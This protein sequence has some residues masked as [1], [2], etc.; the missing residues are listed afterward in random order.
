MKKNLLLI[1]DDQEFIGLYSQILEK[2]FDVK[3][4]HSLKEALAILEDDPFAPDIVLTDI[5]MPETNGFEIYDFFMRNK[6][7]EHFH[8]VFKTSSLNKSVMEESIVN[9][10][11]ELISTYMGNDEIIARLKKSLATS[12]VFKIMKRSE[13]KLMINSQTGKLIFPVQDIPIDFTDTEIKILKCLRD[14][15]KHTPKNIILEYCFGKGIVVTDNNFNT[16][17]TNLRKKLGEVGASIETK[18]N[19]GTKICFS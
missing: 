2:D 9:K 6:K 18:R 11:A 15:E 10:K 14:T 12:P 7:F 19:V 13:L 8:V 16:T 4:A 5:F 3:S 1:D 17:L